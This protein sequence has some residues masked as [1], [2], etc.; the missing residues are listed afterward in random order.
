MSNSSPR[1]S[2]LLA[3]HGFSWSVLE[4]SQGVASGLWAGLWLGLLSREQLHRIDQ[5]SYGASTSYPGA[6]HNL[7]GLFGWETH[8]IDHYFQGCRRLVLLGAGAGREVA[9]LLDRGFDVDA[10]ECHEGLREAGNALLAEHDPPGSIQAMERDRCPKL[11]DRYDGV[12]VGWGMLTLVQGRPTR[13]HLLRDLR[14]AVPSGAP[15]LLSFFIL[16][17]PQRSYRIAARFGNAIRRL[18]GRE[19]LE[20]GDD[21][22]PGYAHFFTRKGLEE[23]LQ[24]AGWRLEFFDRRTYPHAVAIAEEIVD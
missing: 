24:E 2:W 6:D 20:F 16:G 23:E 18:L 10:F 22:S 11:D 17:G 12:I 7:S 4:A 13:L 9:P 21:L 8:A 3:L 15:M 19:Q 1:H 14:S 5:L